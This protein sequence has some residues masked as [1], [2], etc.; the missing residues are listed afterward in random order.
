MLRGGVKH[1]E[2]TRNDIHGT[3]SHSVVP[4]KKPHPLHAMMPLAKGWCK[5]T[6]NY[7]K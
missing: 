7:K 4:V 1:L 3:S 6:R 5:A 2:T